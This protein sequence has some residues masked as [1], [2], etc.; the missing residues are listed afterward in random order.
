MAIVKMAKA[1]IVGL[2]GDRIRILG[3]LCDLGFVQIEDPEDPPEGSDT[4]AARRKLSTELDGARKRLTVVS[5][6]I[7]I[8]GEYARVRTGLFAEPPAFN[9]DADENAL[10]DQARSLI[11]ASDALADV[12]ERFAEAERA[13][14]S[15]TPWISVHKSRQAAQSKRARFEG[16]SFPAVADMDAAEKA[17]RE[18]GLAG[19]IPVVWEDKFRKYVVV[20]AYRPDFDAL[21]KL[22]EPFGLTIIDVPY[23]GATPLEARRKNREE[24]SALLCE[25]DALRERAEELSLLKP[26]FENLY[27]VI[28]AEADRLAE[29]EKLLYSKSAFVVSGWIP[30]GEGER[31]SREMSLLGAWARVYPPDE[32]ETPPTFFKNNRFVEPF[33]EITAMYSYPGPSDADPNPMLA[34]FYFIFYGIMLGDA[35]Y[36]LIMTIGLGAFA[37]LRKFRRGEGGLIKLLAICGVSTALAGLLMNSFFGYAIPGLPRLI[38]PMTDVMLMLGLSLAAGIVHIFAGM[39]MKAY[40]LIRSGRARDAVFDVFFWYIFIAGACCLC[41]PMVAPGFSYLSR[42]GLWLFAVGAL[43]IFLTAGRDAKGFGKVTGGL[44]ALYGITAYAGDILSYSRILALCLTTAVI[45]YVVNILAGMMGP[46]GVIVWLIGHTVNFLV[47]ALG[48]YVHTS[49]LHYVEF[50]G[51]FYEGGGRPFT[52]FRRRTRYTKTT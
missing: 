40:T 3:R 9:P 20:G 22:L 33:Q 28:S 27:D 23:D 45:S 38:D 19:E 50:F 21:I 2:A 11:D 13:R 7:G 32:G 14:E 35:A 51:K 52:P 18:S 24:Q 12:R 30:D 25:M 39:G 1:A 48:T 47:N 10:F 6:A 4:S 17:V 46:F 31:L 42:P 5:K 29:S 43:L 37:W 26:D 8:A 36:G 16:A 34:V 41:L 44:G 49:R 15:H